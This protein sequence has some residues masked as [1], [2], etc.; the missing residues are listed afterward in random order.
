MKSNI[1]N[2]IFKTFENSFLVIKIILKISK[3][4]IKTFTYAFNGSKACIYSWFAYFHIY[5]NFSH[6]VIRD[7]QFKF[8]TCCIIMWLL[9]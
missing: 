9:N 2:I 1:C 3:H 8:L 6:L 7:I 4:E 5:D